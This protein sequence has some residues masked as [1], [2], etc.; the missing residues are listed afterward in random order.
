[1]TPIWD[2]SPD[3]AFQKTCDAGKKIR[4]LSLKPTIM[5]KWG[6]IFKP[7]ERRGTDLD[8]HTH[9]ESARCAR[10]QLH[11]PDM[12]AAA[13]AV[14]NARVWH[15]FANIIA[16][17]TADPLSLPNQLLTANCF[18]HPHRGGHSDAATVLVD[19]PEQPLLRR[20]AAGSGDARLSGNQ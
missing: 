10:L 5:T 9:R 11:S 7:G 4:S 3:H 13:E 8:H 18:P 17:I 14:C 1:M 2:V 19:G 20:N 12:P 15:I 16:Q 6:P